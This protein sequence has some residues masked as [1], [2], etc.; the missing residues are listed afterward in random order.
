MSEECVHPLLAFAQPNSPS[1]LPPSLP[2]TFL[3]EFMTQFS[4]LEE[5]CTKGGAVSFE[6]VVETM[7]KARGP[8]VST[9]SPSLPPYLAALQ[10][11]V[12]PFKPSLPPS[13]PSSPPRKKLG[14]GQSL[15]GCL[16]QR[17]L[18]R[19]LTTHPPHPPPPLPPPLS[20]YGRSTNSLYKI[21]V[22]V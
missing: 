5:Q 10:A 4:Q 14:R 20:L 8:L 17:C 19:R 15:A 11:V 3:Q 2:P 21:C 22:R 16:E 6:A 1:P 12:I 13:L 9:F 7:E 18:A